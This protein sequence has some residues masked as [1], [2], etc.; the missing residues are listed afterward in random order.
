MS[1]TNSVRTHEAVSVSASLLN[2]YSKTD[3]DMTTKLIVKSISV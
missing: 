1:S 2:H 3:P